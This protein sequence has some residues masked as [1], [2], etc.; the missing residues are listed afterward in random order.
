MMNYFDKIGRDKVIASETDSLY[1]RHDDLKTIQDSKDELLKIG[2]EFGNLDVEIKYINNAMFLGKKIYRVEY[3]QF[4]ANEINSILSIK[5]NGN[6]IIE[7]KNGEKV[8]L[9]IN[10]FTECKEIFNKFHED[11][12][13]KAIKWHKVKIIKKAF[14]GVSA[15]KKLEDGTEEEVLTKELYEKFYKKRK[16]NV[17]DT[18]FIRTLF[19]DKETSIYIGNYKKTIRATMKF[20]E[21]DENLNVI[22]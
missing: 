3:K 20:N 12:E 8:E 18:K 4:K 9:P 7:F 13:L 19:N 14:K 17:N 1:I 5:K 2:S 21:Y 22:Y 11:N 15:K 10:Y 6:Y 16:I